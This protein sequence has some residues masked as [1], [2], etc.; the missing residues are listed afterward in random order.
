MCQ[1]SSS[2]KTWINLNRQPAS[3]F[4][5]LFILGYYDQQ[6]KLILPNDNSYEI[7]NLLPTFSSSAGQ[8]CFGE[9]ITD[10]IHIHM[11]FTNLCKYMHNSYV[12]VF[13]QRPPGLLNHI[14]LKSLL[15]SFSFQSIVLSEIVSKCILK[16]GWH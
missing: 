11:S 13:L 5:F 14:K 15:F 8:L 9:R 2:Q 16:G 1:C 10:D 12:P 7:V 6:Q 3:N 4:L